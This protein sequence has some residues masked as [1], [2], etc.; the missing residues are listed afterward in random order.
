MKVKGTVQNE[1]QTKIVVMLVVFSFLTAVVVGGVSL[2]M[3][4]QSARQRIVE[5]NQVITRQVG[6]EINR[7]MDNARSLTETL[8][9]SPEASAMEADKLKVLLVN[10]QQKNPQFELLYVIDKT[11][12]QT[13]RTSGTLGNR[14]DRDYFKEAVRG[15]TYYTDIYISATTNQPTITVSSPIKDAS[16]N[17]VGIVGADISLRTVCEIAE[18]ATIGLNGYIDIV[19][20]KGSLI[21]HPEKAGTLTDNNVSALPYVQ[22]VMQ[23][24]SGHVSAVS[25]AG[26]EAMI[27]YEPINQYHWGVVAYLPTDEAN[28]AYLDILWASLLIILAVVVL[29]GFSGNRM[30]QSITHP[31]KNMVAACKDF[32]VGDFRDKKRF[33]SRQ[34]EIGQLSI[35]LN[36]MRQSLQGLLR[37][38]NESAE[39][40]AASSQQ[41]TA[42]AE[43]SALSVDQVAKSISEVAAG[44]EEQRTA[45]DAASVIIEKMLTAIEQ[46]AGTSSQAAGNS[47]Q[48]VDRT[49]D[50]NKAIEKAA[51]QMAHIEKTVNDSAQVVLELGE[52]S[53]EIGQIVDAISNIAGQTNLLALNAA[54]E[55]ARA[56]EQG[57]GF[58]VVAEEVRKLAEQSQEAAQQIADLIADIQGKTNQAVLAMERGTQE[59]KVGTEVVDAAG[60]TFADI[61]TLVTKVSGQVNEISTAIA[62]MADGSRK[63]AAAM[64]IVDGHSK[65]AVH[66]AQT[67]SAATQ[68]QSASMQEIASS[69]HSL[70][71]L[72]QGLNQVV[73]KFKV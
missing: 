71:A 68:E 19:D 67:V 72:A 28:K 24:E 43:Q 9:V 7:F 56:G 45:V 38:V 34:D 42:S 26:T 17:I 52:Q 31:L 69:S 30:A 21:A 13:V 59:V 41:L 48:V 58:S 60:H 54:I 44:S 63:I 29:A 3:S 47:F 16:G 27:D 32:A 40:V 51:M 5:G 46:A 36:T 39:Q 23:G 12:W 18:A 4:I 49:K 64:D 14:A 2:Y 62:D 25:T 20:S 70:A 53:K 1:L 66:E 50:G 35:A 33:L 8:A 22:A 65:K 61:E 73:S 37:Q 57:K 11:G 10:A 55:A 6:S 15:K